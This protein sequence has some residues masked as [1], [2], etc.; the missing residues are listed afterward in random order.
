MEPSPAIVASNFNFCGIVAQQI[1]YY[2]LNH[3]KRKGEF[4]PRLSILFLLQLQICRY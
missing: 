1:F 4:S 3:K 2:F